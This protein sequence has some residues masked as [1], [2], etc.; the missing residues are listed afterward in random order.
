MESSRTVKAAKAVFNWISAHPH[1]LVCGAVG[2]FIGVLI[3]FPAGWSLPDPAASLV[4]AFAGAAAAVG[5]ALWAANAKQHQEDLKDV[6]HQ[7]HIATIVASAIVPE[8]ASARRNLVLIADNLDR[9]I[10]DAD[11]GDLSTVRAVLSVS[12]LG[13]EMCERFI[14]RF[15]AFG[16]DASQ[17][18]EAVGAILDVGSTNTA[19]V[20]PIRAA[21]WTPEA[22]D[23]VRMQADKARMYASALSRAVVTLAKYHPR[24]D[25]VAQMATWPLANSS[26]ADS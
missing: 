21:G 15:E 5:G 9:A 18:I 6:V 11:S 12:K 4:G 26:S 1:S 24:P 16:S 23:V 7:K 25:E 20:E 14:D 22:K 10:R 3:K 13:S 8:V 17:I 19:L 2:T